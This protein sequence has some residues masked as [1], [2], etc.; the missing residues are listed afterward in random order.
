M[1][2][3]GAF[4]GARKDFLQ[5]QKEVYKAGV[6]GGYA[7]DALAEIQHKYLK[8]FPIDLPQH[9]DPMPEWLV[10]VDDDA[11]DPEQLEPDILA[12]DENEYAA[13]VEK[14]VE[15]RV[16]LTFRQAVSHTT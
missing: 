13:A 2:N 8:R 4:Q 5:S 7:A 11:A 16:L 12:L 14:L 9:K 1:V 10:A 15:R 6:L 3:L